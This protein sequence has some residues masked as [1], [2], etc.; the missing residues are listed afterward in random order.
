MTV[1]SDSYGQ[2]LEGQGPV[3]PAGSSA[4]S[5]TG[6]STGNSRVDAVLESLGRLDDTPVTEHV[7]VFESAHENLRSALAGAGDDQSS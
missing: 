4:G 6:S 2:D 1:T 5:S 3:E 7:A